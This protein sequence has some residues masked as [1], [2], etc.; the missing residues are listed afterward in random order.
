[1]VGIRDDLRRE[2]PAAI[3]EV[4][5]A[6]VQVVMMTGDSKDTAT[7]I[8]RDAGLLKE[9]RPGQIL[10]SSELAAMSDKEVTMLLPRLR[11]VAR[12][13]PTDKSRLV[14]LAQACGMV[15]GMTGDGINDAPALKRADVGFSMG[16]GTEVAKE[17]G[18]IVILDNNFAS[19][20]KAIRYG[21]TIFRSIQ[22]FIVYQFTMNLSAVAVSLIGPF[23]GIDTP[24]TVIQMLW[25]NIIMDTLAG[26]AFAGEPALKEYMNELPKDRNEAVIDRQMIKK[27][28]WMGLYTTGICVSFLWLP[29]FRNTFHF[30]QNPIHFLTAFYALFIYSGVFNSFNARTE[31][32]NPF[33]NIARNP[34]FILIMLVVSLVQL[35]MIYFGGRIFRTAGL[36]WEHLQLVL[37]MALSVIPAEMIRKRLFKKRQKH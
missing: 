35:I 31:G 8:A 12:A 37:L 11:V 27:I 25:I 1:M 34:A 3:A 36:T 13:L 4:Q 5:R 26:L 9:H 21:R 24:V 20:A 6:G 10:T 14:R 30:D 32:M 7:A 2:V 15:A 23:I 18:D 17:A 19:I 28:F 16:S 29:Y 22:K 33:K